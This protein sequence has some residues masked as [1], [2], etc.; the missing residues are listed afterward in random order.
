MT[1]SSPDCP[2]CGSAETT[3]TDYDPEGNPR[4]VSC[5]VCGFDSDTDP[6][7]AYPPTPT[8]RQALRQAVLQYGAAW[9]NVTDAELRMAGAKETKEVRR[10]AEQRRSEVDR[11][12]AMIPEELLVD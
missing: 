5:L 1:T 11:L 10:V 2:N 4:G 7:P 12:I 3:F 8:L 9:Q 6:W